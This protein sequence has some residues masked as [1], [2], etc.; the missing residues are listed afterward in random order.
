MRE[1]QVHRKGF[2]VLQRCSNTLRWNTFVKDADTERILDPLY[3]YAVAQL[4]YCLI[5]REFNSLL[6]VIELLNV[7]DNWTTNVSWFLKTRNRE[8]FVSPYCHSYR[9]LWRGDEMR[10]RILYFSAHLRIIILSWVMHQK[11]VNHFRPHTGIYTRCAL[12]YGNVAWKRLSMTGF[13][14]HTPHAETENF[15]GLNL[16]P[17]MNTLAASIKSCFLFLDLFVSGSPYI[18]H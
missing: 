7:N 18:A 10:G 3:I 17:P 4:E 13:T 1:W 8:T 9:C 5:V 11:I 2:C 15:K 12:S 6:S 14:H 16:P